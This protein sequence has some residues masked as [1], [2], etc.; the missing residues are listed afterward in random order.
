MTVIHFKMTAELLTAAPTSTEQ[1]SNAATISCED[2]L[3]DIMD[4]W[5]SATVSIKWVWLWND[6]LNETWINK[7]NN[8]SYLYLITIQYRIKH[9]DF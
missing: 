8:I 4:K 6:W 2:K 7:L 1:P 9:F 3:P 5:K